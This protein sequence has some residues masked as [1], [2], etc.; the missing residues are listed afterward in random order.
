MI[1]RPFV[2]PMKHLLLLFSIILLLPIFSISVERTAAV[3]KTPE[4]TDLLARRLAY[5]QQKVPTVG[6][7]IHTVK[8]KENLWKIASRH[9]YSVHSIIGCNPQLETYD[10]AIG[11]RI[12]I[13]SKGGSL[14]PVQPGDTWVSVGARYRVAPEKIQGIN[15]GVAALV[16]GSYIFIPGVRPD[17]DL[18]N[19]AMQEKYQL[20]SLFTSPLGGRLSSLFGKRKHPVT[21]SLHSFHGGIDIAVPSNTWVGAAAAGVVT[22]ASDGIGHY[23]TAV[24]VDHED[25]Y[26][27][28]YGHLS[29][30][31][32]HVGQRVKARQ[33]IAKSG[34]TGRVTGPHL[35][36]TIKKNGVPKDPLKYI[37]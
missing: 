28:Q 11:Q 1:I 16:P 24:F 36:F 20:R 27:T 5:L 15:T 2:F 23:G 12:L 32:V 17:T 30:V 13:P 35:H 4:L 22:V 18:M 8:S 31:L 14:H 10:V 6:F 37:W 29:R 34:A 9:H 19:K 26:E 25:G 21:G 3:N 33:L 7:Y